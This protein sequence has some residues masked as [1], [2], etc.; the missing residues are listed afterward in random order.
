VKRQLTFSVVLAALILMA[1]M[2]GAALA[3]LD[4]KGKDFII[5]FL[6]QI[7]NGN[8][9][10]HVTVQY[11]VNSPTFNSTVNVGPGAVTIVGLP[12]SAMNS[13]PIGAPANNA[14]RA[15]SSSEFVAYVINRASATSDAA[16]GLP[17]DTWNTQYIVAD[18]IATISSSPA[19]FIVVA[20]Y[21][22]TNVTI[23]PT[24]NTTNGFT[25]GNSYNVTLNRGQGYLVK[26]LQSLTGTQI[27]AD[28]PVGLTNGVGCTNIFEG[29]CDHIFEIAQPVQSWGL[30]TIGA[31]LPLRTGTAYRMIASQDG[32]DFMLDGVTV[33]TNV[34]KGG[35]FATGKI[36]GNHVFEANKPMFVVQY[37][38][39]L[40]PGGTGDPAMGNLIPPAQYLKAYTFSTVG[41][42]Q[43]AQNFVSIIANN[44]DVG[45]LKLDGLPIAPGQYT[46]IGGSGYSVT[47]Q[48]LGSGTHSTQS[49]NPHGITVEGYN[50]F[51]SYLYPGGALFQ[52]INP[53]GDPYNPVINA[54][55]V[56]GTPPS[57][58]FTATDNI[59]SEDLNN[60]QFLD[61]GEDLNSNNVIDK[62]TGVFQILL[63]P[64]ATN[65]S[66][67]VPGFVPGAG[68]V[69]FNITLINPLQD[70]LGVLR[71]IDG[72][73]N[74]ST[75]NVSLIGF[76][77]TTP[78][79]TWANPGDITWPT[80]LSGV[81]LNATASVPGTMTY[82][83][84]DGTVL[85]PGNGQVLTVNFV[86]ANTNLYNNASATVVINVLKAGS[87]VTVTCSN[88][89]YTGSA[90]ETCTAIATGAGN[91]SVTLTPTYSNNVSAGTA[92]A[93]AHFAGDA[94]HTESDGSGTFIIKKATSAVTV[95]CSDATYTGSA[96]E[97][98]TAAATGA[99]NLNESLTVSYS[100][101]VDAGPASA[102]ASYAGGDNH[103]GSNGSATFTIKKADSTV[104]LT[105]SNPTYN[106]SAHETCTA[107]ATG[108]GNLNQSLTVSYTNNVDAGPAS[109]S[110]SYA[111]DANHNASNG[112]ATFT[113]KKADSTVTVTCSDATYTGSAHETCV[114]EV[115][116]AGNLHQ[117]LTVSY[118]D[119]INAGTA[120]GSASYAGDANHNPSTGSAQFNI[121]KAG[122]ATTVTC[123][124]SVVYNTLA[125][126]PCSAVVTGAGN[127]NQPVTVIYVNNV[128]SGTATASATFAGDANHN[129]SSDSKTFVILQAATGTT[130]STSVNPS[131]LGQSV[132]FTAKVSSPVGGTP[133]G[134]VTFT[135]G[136]AVLGIG[137]VGPTGL[138]TFTTSYLTVGSHPIAATYGGDGNYLG[139]ASN[140]FDQIVYAF[141]GT[142]SFVIGDKN[143][144][145]GNSVMFWGAQ[146]EKNNSL[147]GPMAN[148]S[149]KGFAN[150]SSTNPPAAGG[151][152]RTD[153]GNSSNPPASIPA[154]MGVIVASTD[155]KNGSTISGN[156]VKIVVV[157]TNVGYAANPGNAGTGT[158][159]AILP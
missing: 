47:L 94:F 152:W 115:N 79:I 77:K 2:P 1:L 13:W 73:G 151:S 143:A 8:L 141:A 76:S 32:T 127:L 122:S 91:L 49:D 81:Q 16:L 25:A 74:Q 104:T 95:T 99:G 144:I 58:T 59:P 21:D 129:G 14:V 6:P 12:L 135:D 142:G 20:G 147:T 139:S 37:M 65:L 54:T 117:T 148:A 110:A 45:T 150:W 30:L 119:N 108:A 97:S 11:P 23:K 61:P 145:L 69:S 158:I 86:P 126:T 118:T 56:P 5:T 38:T 114:A 31:N 10:L 33:A 140:P 92:S 44:L 41:A 60:N 102:S 80:A 100:N 130:I 4:N 70:G 136:A 42:G 134:L 103:E 109:A 128:N 19:E 50:G 87:T 36:P 51:D 125:Q 78:T 68:S 64:G 133:T 123:P 84:A 22:G 82:G 157:K 138:A 120:T 62:D 15:F 153:P 28:K 121:A 66:L 111:G 107:V 89:T 75:F 71:V 137:S 149:F 159:I 67:N 101:N 43:F 40:P 90:H 48:P 154:Y 39:G 155:V 106:G 124:V 131:L 52:A 98:C 7:S 17:I 9:E 3:Q 34:S 88:A 72:A 53:I 24:A 146:W 35:F 132:T 26:S 83:P 93:S 29:A 55:F 105:C 46:P 85:S 113:I 57:Y 27:D 116:G 96:I 112:T 63:D 18:Y 156:S